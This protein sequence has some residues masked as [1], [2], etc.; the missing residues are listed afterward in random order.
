MS[1]KQR[2]VVAPASVAQELFINSEADITI[3][4]GSAGSSK[5]YSILLR[6]LRYANTSGTRGVI[7]R[8][9]ST[10][11]TMPN[12]LWQQAIELYSKID[13]NLKIRQRDME[14]VFSSGAILKFSHFENEAAK[15]KFKGLQADYIAFDESTEFTEEMVTYLLSRNRNFNVKHKPCLV[16]ATNPD[17]KSFLLR[18]VDW[19]LDPDTG[20]PDPAKRGVVR[21][22]V[23]Q[24]DEMIWAD[25]REELEAIYGSGSDSGIMSMMVIGSTCLD[26]P[27]LMA[28]D[29]SYV[30]RLKALSTVETNRLLFG[31]WY[32]REEATGYFKREWVDFMPY[33]PNSVVKRVRAWDLA[34]TPVS[35]LNKSP[36]YTCGTL[37]SKDK[38]GIYYIEDSVRI[39]ERVHTVEKLI[40]E[41]AELDGF[42]T[43]ISIPSDPGASASAYARGLQKKLAEAGFSVR[44]QK[45][46]KSKL[47]RFMPFA[48][49]AESR[50][51]K[52]VRGEWNEWFLKELE[53]FEGDGKGHDDACDTCSDAVALLRTSV[54]I[55]N[56]TLPDFSMSNPYKINY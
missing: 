52:V 23:R 36:D 28:A 47:T 3:A 56:F 45:P 44:L 10:Q 19:W 16:M 17:Y 8:R 6:F 43:I 20:I 4:S 34:F 53:C 33:P 12:G 29:P 22:F 50:Y 48:A 49:I 24:N 46:I 55:P 13:P 5:S 14:L 35:D 54:T 32:A 26:N 18:W 1:N 15:I 9:T 21:Y 2:V 30:G 41:T 51:L 31:S 40:F 7:F 38:D 25:K 27:Y 11:L 39:R 37:I 42:D